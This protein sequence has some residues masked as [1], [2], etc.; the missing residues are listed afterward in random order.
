MV[1]KMKA[2]INELVANTEDV[3]LLDLVRQMLKQ[4][5]E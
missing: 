3:A 2:E 1:E 5:Q 4:E